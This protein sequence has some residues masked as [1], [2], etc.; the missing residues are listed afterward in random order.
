MFTKVLIANRGSIACRII[1]TLRRMGIGSVAVYS[2]AD[3]GSLHVMQAD[4]AV[5]IGPAPAHASYMNSSGLITAARECRAAAIHPGYGFLS[6]S[7]EFAAECLESGLTFIGPTPDN[8]RAFALKHTA[9]EHA[10]AAGVPLLPGS[11]LLSD[12]EAARDAARSIGFPVMLKATAG[13]GGIGM[14]VCDDIE[15]LDEAFPLVARLGGSHF[16]NAAIFLERFVPE[17]RHVE[18]QVF[19][20]GAGR[21]VA[22]GERDCSLQRRNQKVI[23]ET[24]A[25]GLSETTRRAMA[26]SAVRLA[27][28]VSYRSAGTV[29]FLFDPGRDEYFFLEVNTRLQVEHGITEQVTG[30]DLVEWMLR[31]AA[32]QHAIWTSGSDPQTIRARP[33]AARCRRAFMRRIRSRK[34]GRAAE[35]LPTVDFPTTSASTP[36]SRQGRKSR[37]TMIRCWPS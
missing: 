13:G 5:C 19:G 33:G 4:E 21:V 16:H 8:M 17:A 1:R 12:I 29:E 14:R 31:C 23:E 20:D 28:S 22:L 34:A 3:A 6:E 30:I 24:P 7:P 37:R 35:P 11:N 26:E 27:S 36:G 25:P 10:L 18:V 15:S 32:G 9:R 2:E